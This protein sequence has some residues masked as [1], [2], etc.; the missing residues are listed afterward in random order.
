MED[1]YDFI[2]DAG[3]PAA[4]CELDAAGVAVFSSGPPP[5]PVVVAGADA[6]LAEAAKPVDG[7]YAPAGCHGGRPLYVRQAAPGDPPSAPLR[8][9]WYSTEFHD[10]DLTVGEEPNPVRERGERGE[11]CA[12]A[13]TLP[14]LPP[15]PLTTPLPPLPSFRTTSPCTAAAAGASRA[16]R[17]RPP[18]PGA[19]RPT[20]RPR[21]RRAAP[22]TGTRR[23]K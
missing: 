6:R 21:P 20:S 1:D 9:L 19:W 23:P 16:L 5:C 12:R 10:W 11:G 8:V 14:P 2:A 18:A 13:H 3:A 4:D 17:P 15:P 7:T 22:P